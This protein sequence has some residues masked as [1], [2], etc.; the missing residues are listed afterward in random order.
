MIYVVFNINGDIIG[1]A[2]SSERAVEIH[3]ERYGES[4]W[5]DRDFTAETCTWMFTTEYGYLFFIRR[6]QEFELNK[7]YD[8]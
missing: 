3:Q 8:Q 6:I 7:F 5:A 4:E 2:D 1:V